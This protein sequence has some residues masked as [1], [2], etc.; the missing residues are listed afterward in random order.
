LTTN[1]NNTGELIMAT[2]YDIVTAEQ[3]A[4]YWNGIE[5]PDT[6]MTAELFPP[7]KQIGLDL[8]WIKGSRGKAIL[9]KPSA[10]DAFA[11]PR[12]RVGFTKMISQMPFFR[13]SSY[14]DEELR[15]Q[16][17][18][19]L[20]SNTQSLIDS[21]AARIFE[22]EIRLIRGAAARREQMRAM[23][24]STGSIAYA[25]NGQ[26]GEFDYQLPTN[27]KVTVGTAWSE[28]T[29]DI[30]QDIKNGK[31]TI[32]ED[33]GEIVSRAIC[34]GESWKN[35]RN[36]EKIRNAIFAF[37][38]GTGGVLSDRIIRTFLMDEVGLEIIVNDFRYSE[39]DGTSTRYFT[40]NTFSMFPAGEL[41]KTWFGTTPEE[42]DLT[43][44]AAANVAI[45]DTGVAITTSKIINPV[46]VET[47]VSQ[48]CLPS[49][50]RAESVYI[51]TTK[52]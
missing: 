41:G 46:Q 38:A 16:F 8:K 44:N 21:A 23:L 45:V 50:E 14:I 47:I 28:P 9:L 24:L 32:Q 4:A 29:A 37:N 18:L 52:V 17:N 48:I 27:H 43:T 12:P 26:N 6:Y 35:I 19:I 42:S 15:Q 51:L 10:F 40:P 3:L 49:F 22:D 31:Q 1:T 13:E 20:M 11:I 36:N 33:T 39:E 30:L 34:D 7:S 5:K 2:L 25:D